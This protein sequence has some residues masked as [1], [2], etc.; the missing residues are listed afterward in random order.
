ML[1]RN[2]F[3][4][5]VLGAACFLCFMTIFTAVSGGRWRSR[6]NFVAAIAAISVPLVFVGTIRITRHLVIKRRQVEERE[7][8]GRDAR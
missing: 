7:R 1:S 3:G 6:A 2:A 5:L 8:N 4:N